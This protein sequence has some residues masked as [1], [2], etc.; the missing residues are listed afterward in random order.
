MNRRGQRPILQIAFDTWSLQARYRNHGIYNYARNLLQ[1]FSG[2]AATLGVEIKPFV[3]AGASNDANAFSAGPGFSP[4]QARLLKSDRL[5]RFGGAWLAALSE[6]ADLVFCP[7]F[8]S[9][10]PGICPAVSTIHDA[11]PVI[12]PSASRSITRMQRLFLRSAAR[13]SHAIITDSLCSKNDLLE[14][15][16]L[17]ESKVSVVYLGYD[18]S[19][20]N[21][22]QVDS[23]LQKALLRKHGLDRPYIIHHGVVQPR[24]NLQRLVQAFRLMLARVPGL[25][26]D[27]VLAGPLGWQYEEILTEI[28]SGPS[29]RGKI[30][31]TG[32]L[33][34]P[35]MAA[36]LKGAAL[37]V[38]P[39][40]Y[41][42]FC[43]PM[44][45]AMACGIPTIAADASC[46]PEVSGG[47]LRYFDPHLVD[48]IASAMEE[49]LENA[50]LRSEL[51]ARGLLRAREF[52]WRRC[53][54]ETLALLVRFAEERSGA[55]ASLVR[56][57]G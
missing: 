52:D 18:K 34:D 57:S 42:G 32:A 11:T 44:V 24:K 43:L 55:R 41:E 29:G 19:T 10:Q 17:P 20:Y 31:L 22:E 33:S 7:S 21:T 16:G 54:Q 53:A 37:A 49:A 30:V 40:L 38:I 23:E 36:I 15:Y 45:E 8:T 35:E 56:S 1:Q 28:G 3:C 51:S 14:I 5:W 47:V 13:L 25:E 12:M 4:S 39:S 48:A 9:L 2:E 27:L 50:K 6:Q 26:F 46:L